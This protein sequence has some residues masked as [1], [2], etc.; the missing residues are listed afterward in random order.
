VQPRFAP[1]GGGE[2]VAAWTLEA[3]KELH[4]VTVLSWT[5]V[6]VD[7]LNHFFGTQLRRDEFR[8]AGPPALL[9]V[10]VDALVSLDGDPYSVQRYAALMRVARRLRADHDVVITTFNEADLGGP[11]IQYVH[12]PWCQLQWARLQ[13]AAPLRRSLARA[14]FALRPWRL[15]AGFSFARMRANLTLVNSDWTGAWVRDAYG[16]P[17]VTVHPPIPGCFPATPWEEREP[18]IVCVGRLTPSKELET[19]LE[20]AARLR[21]R[22]AA[23]RLHVAGR[24]QPGFRSY[25]E[26]L[27]RRAAA[28]GDW[29]ELHE[30]LARDALLEL[31]GRQRFGL[32]A[33]RHEPFGIAV[34]EMARAGCV[35]LTPRSGGQLEITGGDE[36]LVY[37]GVEDAVE[38]LLALLRSPERC[39]R[40]REHLLRHARRFDVETFVTRMRELVAGFG[41]DPA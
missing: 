6:D 30:D 1:I 29:V 21:E 38:K 34:A 32:H 7:G 33:T 39:S 25:L 20:I 13:A 24:S 22:G 18:G 19:A 12:Q 15:L 14:D 2:V 8:Q 26:G 3:L 31:V 10:V 40:A 23:L 4:E 36:S 37:D 9:R 11:A 17:T 41:R 5:P 28:L 27:R 35:V 16:V